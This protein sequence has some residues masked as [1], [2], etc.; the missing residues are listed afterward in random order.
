MAY[1]YDKSTD[2]IVISGW[3]KG[4]ASSPYTG[5]ANM[6]NVGIS[7]YPSVA[8]I[9]YQRKQCTM[10]GG[11][12][13]AGTHS[14]NAG[15]NLGWDFGSSPLSMT[16]PVA[17]AVS[18]AG[19]NYVLD[20]S[21][22]V[23]KQSAVNSS[24]FNVIENGGGRI[25]NGA[26]GLAYWNNYIVVFGDGLIEFCGNGTGDAGVTSSNWNLTATTATIN[27]T[28]GFYPMF[29]GGQPTS[30][31]DFAFASAPVSTA[32]SATLAANWTGASGNYPVRFDNPNQ[33]VRTVTFTNNSTSV[34]WSVG[35]TGNCS[36]TGF[37]MYQLD[38][39]QPSNFVGYS[40]FNDGSA[41]TFS[42]TVSLPTGL[43][44]GTVYYLQNVGATGSIDTTGA[45][46]TFYVSTG[47]SGLFKNAVMNSPVIQAKY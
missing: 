6:R 15:N 9:N 35:L 38:A 22:N 28:P 31:V 2:S 37:Y 4:I 44:A 34:S 41:V 14:I 5:I 7:Y 45:V 16:N 36:D 20:T 19:L 43:T 27:L 1:Q 24:T 46:N 26:G 3:E 47:N 21:G 29:T 40:L 33:D 42:S 18:P 17:K 10:G 8:Y 13:F 23:W 30:A 25:G 11:T 12:F 39:A 32:T